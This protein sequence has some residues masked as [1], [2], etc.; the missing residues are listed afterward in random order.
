MLQASTV[1][2]TG[3]VAAVRAAPAQGTGSREPAHHGAVCVCV[4]VPMILGNSYLT[5]ANLKINVTLVRKIR[6]VHARTERPIALE[7]MR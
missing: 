4:F 7:I 3:S 2:P 1:T 5:N 6:T